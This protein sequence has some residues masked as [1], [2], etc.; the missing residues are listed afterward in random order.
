[1]KELSWVDYLTATG[2]VATPLLVLLLG[3]IGWRIRTSLDRQFALEDKLRESRI[4]TYNNILEPF[5]ILLMSEA[6]WLSD[7][8]NKGKDKRQIA[9]SMLLSLSYRTTGFKLSLVGSD[10]VIQ[11]YN[12]LMQ[13]FFNTNEDDKLTENDY[14]KILHMLGRFLLE[15]R[16]S[17][18]NEATKLDSWDMLEW[19][20]VDARKLRS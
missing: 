16:R 14:K 3:A 20:I 4:E 10:A 17:M 12:D 7:K 5:I 13:F 8:K 11:S 2:A 19:F 1:M 18:G 15:I 6:A 9:L